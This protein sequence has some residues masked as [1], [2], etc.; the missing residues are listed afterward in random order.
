MQ[1][2]IKRLAMDGGVPNL[3]SLKIFRTGLLASGPVCIRG[4]V[5]LARATLK[6]APGET[7]VAELFW[8]DMRQEYDRSDDGCLTIVARGD[9][10]VRDVVM[11]RLRSRLKATPL[12]RKGSTKAITP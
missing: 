9:S 8:L 10:V 3:D 4:C 5:D 6:L 7:L 1:W 11:T 12:R 2:V